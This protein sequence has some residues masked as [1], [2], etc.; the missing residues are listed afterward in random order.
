MSSIHKGGVSDV[1]SRLAFFKGLQTVTN[2][3]HAT[4][5]IDE[6]IFEL[7]ADICSLFAADRLTI[8]VV[9][10]SKTTISSRVKTGLHS[11]RTI[12]LPIAEN[13][14]AGYVALTGQMLNIHDAYD[15][16]ELKAI[17][18]RM[19]FRREVDE[20][21][22]YRCHQM[23]VAPISS[24][25][26]GDVLGVIQLINTR[27]GEVFSAIAEEG[28]QGLGQ[29]LAVAFAQRRHALV[30]PKSKY[31]GLVND[32]KLTSAEL[33]AATSQAREQGISLEQLLLDDYK[34]KPVD[35]GSAISRFFGV[36]YEPFRPDRVKPLDL[37]RN[38]KKDY[39][40]QAQWLPLEENPDGLLIL[41]TDP[42]QAV[43]SRV[44]QNVFP[45]A[46]PVF[47]VTTQVEFMQTV[48]QFFGGSMTD[49]ASVS[50]LLSDMLDDDGDG[51]PIAEDVSAAVDNELVKLVNRII[52]DAHRQ[53]A[54]D[55]HIEPRPGKEKTQIR[56]RLD[57]SLVPYIE[58]P[59]S[60]RSPIVTRIKIMCD[61]DISER[62]KPQDG[63]I[64]FRRFGPLDIELRVATV[65]T[66]GGVEDVVMRLLA[67]SEPIPLEKLGLLDSNY[68]RL[69]RTIAKPYGIFFVCGPTGSGKTTTL[70]S[71]LGHI[72]TPETK[73]WTAE[74]PVE[75]TQKGLR[76]VQVNRKA[77]LDFPT[78]MRS[79]LRADPD[80]IMVGEMR[81]KETVSIGLEAS[82]TGHLVFSTLHTNSAPESI[83]R[84]LDMGM[85]PFNFAD[86]LLGILAQRLAK[87][88]CGKCRKPYHPTEDE[89]RHM[90]DE[91]CEDLRQTPAFVE[92]PLVAR[93][94]IMAGWRQRY[95]DNKGR[96]T[97]YEPVGCDQ[98]NAGYKGRLGL[99][100]LMV[101]SDRVKAL[102]Q[103]RARV[104][105]LLSV[106][107]D[108]GMRT[109]RQD[110]I[111][112]VLGG[113]TD[114]KQV[115]KV[116][117]R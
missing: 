21:T 115:R 107:L 95:A 12:R 27:S 22:G 32:A 53:G 15:E 66:T 43:A 2:R 29:T 75:I 1:A 50:E 113:L 83:V 104:A 88:L 97:L 18:M 58:V 102:I 91:Y 100:E 82:L 10:E 63:K 8:Y 35:I 56:F 34:L 80:V 7:S 23:L 17:S 85:D 69:K 74:D 30:Q 16:R 109:L 37:L 60:Y 3:I 99:H 67:N 59:S 19:E 86:A 42:E 61:L 70:H 33:E 52:I 114:L 98:C 14:V 11:I 40:Q 103:E 110:G 9:D 46:T 41:V 68:E 87:R 48:A 4:E 28:I 78:V 92:D 101:G 49:D 112:K 106:A 77:G 90:L 25:E 65:P 116:C 79:F 24:A 64:K 55:I 26:T 5:N 6:I 111:E 47:C 93:E 89:V 20:R 45:K 117:I 73:I 57:G 31:E 62:R 108:E 39:V 72:N 96:F 13:S 94:Q 51:N 105:T 71:I 44:V 81:D 76:Q 54:S 84:L 36:P 38:L